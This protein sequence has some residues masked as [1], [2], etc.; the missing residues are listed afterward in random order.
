MRNGTLL[1]EDSPARL[2]ARFGCATM[3]DVFLKLS[4]RQ[5][6]QQQQLQVRSPAQPRGGSKLLCKGLR[7]RVGHTGNAAGMRRCMTCVL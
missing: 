4:V 3:E 6:R 7:Y 5:H 2:L 1:A